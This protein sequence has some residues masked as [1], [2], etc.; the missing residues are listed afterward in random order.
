MKLKNIIKTITSIIGLL[1]TIF[2]LCGCSGN[3]KV[4]EPPLNEFP[5]PNKYELDEVILGDFTVEKTFRGNFK[6]NGLY[7]SSTTLVES[8]FS[9]GE[10][11]YVTYIYEGKTI[12]L[13]ATLIEA[14]EISKSTFIAKH[15]TLH[16]GELKYNWPGEFSI[17]TFQQDNCILVP[18]DAVRLFDDNGNAIVYLIN[19]NEILTEKQIK[20]GPSN[21]KYYQVVE[22]LTPGEKVV[23]K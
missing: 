22:G 1:I 8:G 20:V 4:I 10:K 18:K 12:K 9:A 14:P 6:Y 17:V 2:V 15:E 16:S 13:E 5:S 21:N 11:G 19:E 7:T 3:F 23:V